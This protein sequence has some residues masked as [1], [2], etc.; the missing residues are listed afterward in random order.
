M[1][2]LFLS[3]FFFPEHISTGKYNTC[4]AKALV[5]AGHDV[6]VVVSHPIYPNW[7]AEISNA[8][9]PKIE[10]IRGGG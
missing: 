7:C 5:L 2:T 8:A 6:T 4:L 1:K 10:I 9:L 3:P